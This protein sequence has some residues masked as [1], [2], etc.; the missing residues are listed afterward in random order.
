MH[1]R[2]SYEE[3]ILGTLKAQLVDCA[4]QYPELTKEF[5]R[6]YSRLSSA[7]KSH[8]I[9]FVLDTMPAFR[10]HFDKCLDQR[11]LT[12][13]HLIHF[14]SGKRGYVIPRLFRGLTLRVFDRNGAL[15]LNPDVNAVRLLRQ[16]L[17][18][19]RKLRKASSARDSGNTV[20]EFFRTDMEVQ[21]GSLSWANHSD[22]DPDS[23]G[24]LSFSD[25]D[26]AAQGLKCDQL[27]LFAS[28]SS[29]LIPGLLDKVQRVADLL[30]AHL[31]FYD[32]ME[33]KS[34]HGPG[35]VSDHRFGV[36]KY[37]FANWPDR[38]ESVFPY[39]DFA[40]ANYAQVKLESVDE[41]RQRGFY[42]EF[43]ARLCS[44]PKTLKTPRLI[45]TEPTALQWC[46]QNV[47][48]FLYDRIR[49]TL[50]SS[51]IDLRRQEEN[52]DL[53]LLASHDG[54]HATIDL[55]SASDRISCWHVERLFRRSPSLLRALQATRSAWIWQD[56]C[57][58]SPKYHVLRKYSTMGNATTFPVQSLFFLSLALGTYLT[59]RRLPISEKVIR[60]IGKRQVRVFG[61]DIIVPA[62]CSG[63]LTELINH[64][65]L[66]VNDH[67]SFTEG[68]FRE[69]CG[70]DAF[71]GTNVTT[72]N[73]LDVPERSS[74]GSIVS[75]VDVHHNL[76]ERGYAATAHYLQKTAARLVGNTIRYVEHGSGLFGWS[77]LCG[78]EPVRTRT[79]WNRS[80]QRLEVQCLRLATKT[81]RL[82]PEDTSGLLQYFTEAPKVV[83]C[84]D[85]SL[86]YLSQRPKV[87]VSLG[88]VPA[89]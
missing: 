3:F 84:S 55:S 28:P 51:F 62:D 87:K 26:P 18:V 32:P 20:L 31:G 64:L 70:V 4:N 85:S 73:I 79:R 21:N 48:D 2:N 52:G 13:S 8:G 50:I 56:L 22:F 80:L 75:S 81:T 9:R 47:R 5:D 86:G 36:N 68:N 16:L 40:V 11:R 1:S 53:A 15:R 44:V 23:A 30:V 38:L 59:V 12:Q 57:R 54:K 6:D 27:S 89:R 82:L 46:Q 66:K 69:S 24:E 60:R 10:K 71:N 25:S 45:A 42:K 78:T 7:V 83:E 19:L 35:A 77:D 49:S 34:R 14:G 33:W 61:D 43:P 29:T 37:A 76:L 72:V 17:G 39:A 88:W 74:P 65:G 41:A 63:P 58:Y 67:K